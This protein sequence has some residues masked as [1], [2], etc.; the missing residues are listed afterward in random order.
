MMIRKTLICIFL[1]L[2]SRAGYAQA[3][4]RMLNAQTKTYEKIDRQIA[5]NPFAPTTGNYLPTEKKAISTDK[6]IVLLVGDSMVGRLAPRF[7]D[8]AVKNNFEFHSEAWNGS[9]TRDWAL[10]ADLEYQIKRFR[11]TY[12]IISLG[13]NDLGYRDYTQREAAVRSILQVIGD[14]PYVWIGPLSYSRFPN[15]TIVD[16]IQEQTSKGRFFDSSYIYAKRVDGI[17]PTQLSANL[18]VDKVVEWMKISLL[19]TYP[20]PLDKP[21]FTTRYIPDELHGM[22]YRGRK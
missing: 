9:T 4:Y 2:A 19:A 10:A 11:P 17:H 20:L 6:Q 16:I 21:D 15:R 22:K 8:Y 3:E 7:N 18:W 5:V 13:T 12:I 1:L 14:I